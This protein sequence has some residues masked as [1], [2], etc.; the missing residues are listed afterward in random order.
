[1]APGVFLR[2]QPNSSTRLQLVAS[3][4]VAILTQRSAKHEDDS[5]GGSGVIWDGIPFEHGPFPPFACHP[6]PVRCHSERSEESRSAQGKHPAG[7][8]ALGSAR[9]AQ[10]TPPPLCGHGWLAVSDAGGGYRGGHS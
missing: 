1:M 7:M 6:E 5:L 4:T 10:M 2:P 3:D 8:T 9:I